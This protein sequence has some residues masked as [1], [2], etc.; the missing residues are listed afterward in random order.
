METLFALC[1]ASEAKLE[2]DDFMPERQID[3]GTVCAYCGGTALRWDHVIAR[4]LLKPGESEWIVAACRECKDML[5]DRVLHTVPARAKWLYGRY[6]KKY[7]KLLLNASWTDE[8]IEELQ[9]S[10]KALVLETSL[11]QAELDHRLA[12]LRMIA[13]KDRDYLAPTQFGGK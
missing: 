2:G 6:R 4:D 7:A 12:H 8:E 5:A 9:G 11:V 3:D 13:A 1:G 10:F